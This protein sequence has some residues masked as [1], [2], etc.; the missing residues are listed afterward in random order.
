M[1][2]SHSGKRGQ[3]TH[4]AV[5]GSEFCS[6]HSREEDRIKGYR[7][8]DPGL[9]ERM[10]HFSDDES[11][12]TVRQEIVLLRTLIEDRL[13]QCDSKAE[14]QAAFTVVT[15]HIAQVNKLVEN[16]TRLEKANHIL[17]SKDA[18]GKLGDEIVTILIEELEH[19]PGHDTIIDKVAARIATAVT[20]ARNED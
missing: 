10:A 2:C 9:R 13:A 8:S 6:K 4:S 3:C 16:L 19:V 20:D 17:L 5:E 12:Q 18:A 11:L 7:L 15:P 14:R 1:R